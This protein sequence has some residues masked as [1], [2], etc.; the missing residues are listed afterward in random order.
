M[1]IKDNWK[2]VKLRM[3]FEES[4]L[5]AH[6]YNT[7]EIQLPCKELWNRYEN[8]MD[9]FYENKIDKDVRKEFYEK[10]RRNNEDTYQSP[11]IQLL[12][13]LLIGELLKKEKYI[14]KIITE[15]ENKL[16]IKK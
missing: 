7:D 12:Y 3:S 14:E 10:L 13:N 9:A 1:D 15:Y 16:N 2:D 5:K 8:L 11:R 6:L 4:M